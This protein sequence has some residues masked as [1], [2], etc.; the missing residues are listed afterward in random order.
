MY[1]E[2][3][4]CN[5]ERREKEDNSSEKTDPEKAEPEIPF[6]CTNPECTRSRPN[7][8]GENICMHVKLKR[9]EEQRKKLNREKSLLPTGRRFLRISTVYL[10]PLKAVQYKFPYL[11]CM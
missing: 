2:G 8:E 6:V 4:E 3:G 9:E 5:E 7:D 1:M 11:C 10:T